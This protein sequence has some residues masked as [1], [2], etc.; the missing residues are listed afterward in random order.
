MAEAAKS[1]S[2]RELL[3]A[4]RDRIAETIT[5]DC[6]PRDMASL[7]RRLDD[8][9][10]DIEQLDLAGMGEGSVVATTDDEDFDAASV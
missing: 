7:T 4:L 5:A 10:K 9:S 8:I 2:R 3:V 6:P 1:G